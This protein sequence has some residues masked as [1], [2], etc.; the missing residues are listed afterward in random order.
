MAPMAAPL[1]TQDMEDLAA[2][3]SSQTI[4]PGTADES[5]VA[6]GEAIYKGGISAS[7]V[8]ACAACH[9]PTGS[10]NPAAKFP[11][12]AGQH[13]KYIEIQ[14]KNFRDGKRD[15]D[16]GRMMRNVAAKMTDAEIAAVAQYMQGLQ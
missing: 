15:N 16:A 8:P 14:L 2:Y 4:K 13:A 12:V 7:G 3:F 10:G 11:R 5:K 9:G 1:S 6:Q